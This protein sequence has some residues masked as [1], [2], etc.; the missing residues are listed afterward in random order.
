MV[1]IWHTVGSVHET[2]VAKITSDAA[3]RWLRIR[4]SGSFACKVSYCL[5]EAKYRRFISRV[6]QSQ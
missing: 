6:R 5:A 2:A 1:A 3:L 4:H